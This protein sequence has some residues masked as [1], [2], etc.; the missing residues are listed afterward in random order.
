MKPVLLIDDDDDVLDSYESYLDVEDLSEYV[1]FFKGGRT[2]PEDVITGREL[3]ITDIK[4]PVEDGFAV[5]A[6]V[7][8]SSPATSIWVISG[9]LDKDLEQELKSKGV[10]DV[11]DKGSHLDHFVDSL[12]AFLKK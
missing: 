9:H 1:D 2:V 10:S 12:R 6:K 7:A 5:M 11:F 4:M 8:A 3:V